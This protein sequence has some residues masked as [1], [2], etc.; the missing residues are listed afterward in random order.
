[1]INSKEQ[2]RTMT[3]T[4]SKAYQVTVPSAVRKVLGLRPGDPVDFRIERGRVMLGRAETRE[5]RVKRIF[6]ELAEWREGL[7]D[8][9]KEKIQKQAGWTINQYHE[10]YD[11]LPETKAYLREKYGA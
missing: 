3:T 10:Y 1:M 6:G 5:E 8:E 7:S 2:A 11:N 9:T 4:L